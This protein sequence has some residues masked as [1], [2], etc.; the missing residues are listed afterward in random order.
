M[1][2]KAHLKRTLEHSNALYAPLLRLRAYLC[3][4]AGE[5]ELQL[6]PRLCPGDETA[7]DV[8][9]NHG[10]YLRDSRRL[11]AR[12]DRGRAP[13]PMSCVG[14][15]RAWGEIYKIVEPANQ[16]LDGLPASG[17]RRRVEEP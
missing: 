11:G 8:G 3:L 14:S 6:L 7:I 13:I 12:C 1:A 15:R 17:P 4:T 9:A 5:P 10:N 2:L 16:H